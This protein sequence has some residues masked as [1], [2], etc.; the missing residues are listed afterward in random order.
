MNTLPEELLSIIYDY[1]PLHVKCLLSCE[2][3]NKYNNEHFEH[4]NNTIYGNHLKLNRRFS[5]DTYVRRLIKN[6][7]Y[8]VFGFVL[9]NN[10]KQWR[11]IKKT[12][13]KNFNYKSKLLFYSFYC[14]ECKSNKC[15]GKIKDY[16]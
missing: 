16:I 8:Y 2:N 11:K 6:D 4:L 3:Y 15:L 12:R 13:Y 5:F 7:M 1:I 14:I 9:K 10:M